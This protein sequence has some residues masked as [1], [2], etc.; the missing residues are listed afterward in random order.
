[1][2]WHDVLPFMDEWVTKLAAP[3][4]AFRQS[5]ADVFTDSD[6]GYYFAPTRNAIGVFAPNASTADAS[7]VKQAV[8][9]ASGQAPLFLSYQELTDPD[10]EWVKVAYSTTVR[11][12]G[13][14]LNFF[15]GQY[16]GGIPN[17]PS[18]LAAMLTSGVLG[19]G[20][21]WGGG[22]LLEKVMPQHYGK[23]LSRTGMLLG[24]LAGAVPG[25][26]WGGTN[27]LIN[28]PFND[29]SLL[30]HAPNAEPDIVGDYRD[31]TNMQQDL[32]QPEASE[33]LEDITRRAETAP[34]HRFKFSAALDAVEL[35]PLYLAACLKTASAF[36]TQASKQKTN[37]DVNIDALGRT[38]WESGASPQ[39]A[40]ATLAGMQAAQR[41]PDPESQPGWVTG[42]QLGQLT[43]QAVGDYGKGYL[44]GTA[45]NAIVGTPHR[46]SLFGVG[47]VALGLIGTVIPKLFGG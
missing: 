13:E 38:L 3:A 30:N 20:L 7:R 36:G 14:L 33:L 17:S 47:N 43:A 18:P 2:N 4:Y 31:G 5:I 41:M 21:G 39:L 9:H 32:Q 44:V 35:S 42:R 19:A 25:A 27:T 26:I 24:G 15:P 8:C 29:N 40:T 37:A 45:L 10:A 34:L 23:N 22:K 16:P 12:A 11:R 6:V 28:K 1:M 46:P